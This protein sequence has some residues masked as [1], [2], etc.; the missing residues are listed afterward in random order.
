MLVM[1]PP[2]TLRASLLDNHGFEP[3][4]SLVRPSSAHAVPKPSLN[5]E[6]LGRCYVCSCLVMVDDG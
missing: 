6:I 2:F 1:T 3:S 4:C 5:S